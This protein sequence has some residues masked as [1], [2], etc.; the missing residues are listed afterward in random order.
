MRARNDNAQQFSNETVT[1]GR[2]IFRLLQHQHTHGFGHVLVCMPDKFIKIPIIRD[3]SLKYNVYGALTM[4]QLSRFTNALFYACLTLITNKTQYFCHTTPIISEASE[5][6]LNR[7]PCSKTQTWSMTKHFTLYY[8]IIGLLSQWYINRCFMGLYCD[9][10]P[11]TSQ[12]QKITDYLYTRSKCKVVIAG[13]L[14][15]IDYFRKYSI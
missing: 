14:L 6:V 7:Q 9:T 4:L 13:S 15:K 12:S 3:A 8:K 2:A 5:V 10:T 11:N 1:N